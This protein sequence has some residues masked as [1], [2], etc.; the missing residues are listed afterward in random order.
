LDR[1]DIGASSAIAS[2]NFESRGRAYGRGMIQRRSASTVLSGAVVKH[3][4]I[5]GDVSCST[6]TMRRVAPFYPCGQGCLVDTV[7][8][9][10]EVE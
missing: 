3:N 8:Q 9:G 2:L 7:R 4:R 10:A 1:R 6:L 5:P